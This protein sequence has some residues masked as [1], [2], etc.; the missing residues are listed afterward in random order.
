MTDPRGFLTIERR[1][2][3]YRPVEARRRDWDDVNAAAADDLVREQARRCMD[4]G[5]PFCHAGCPLGNLI[6]DW[7]DLV[8]RGR[9]RDALDRLHATNNFPEFTGKLCP[10]P[11]EE[12]CV[13]QINDDAVTIKQVE[14][15][16]VDRGFARGWIRPRPPE[17]TTSH[18]VAVIGSGP[19]GLAAAQQLRRRGHAVVVYERDDRIGGL[20]RYG[21]PDFKL[22]KRDID[23]RL[24]QL[25]AEGVAFE[26]GVTVDDL[27][28]LE[29]DAVVLATGAQ[30]HRDLD[31]PGRDLAGIGLA[32]PYLTA[33]NRRVAGLPAESVTA[34][35][36]RVVILGGGDTGADCLGAAIREGA[37]SVALVGHGVQPPEHREPHRTWPDWPKLLR[38]YA[39]HLEGGDRLFE[40]ETTG[41]AGE[42]AVARLE[43]R[44]RDGSPAA[45]DVD[46][47]LVAVGFTGI[48]RNDRVY[49]NV[50][51]GPRDTVVVDAG[52]ATSRPGVFAAGDCVRGADL[53][54]TA[55]A[56]G[57]RCAVAVDAYLSRQ[58]VA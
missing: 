42:A 34:S 40:L 49:A 17:R 31:L 4:C 21:I 23:R 30:R 12:A 48:E 39:A 18:R 41:F 6:P 8:E 58:P 32:M 25:V 36:R 51:V 13:L 1:V 38:T 10:A 35:G 45:L 29:A 54:V 2:A 46:M 55:I 33:C 19:A 16:I 26:T 52:F 3:G 53:I 20:L 57:R 22:A 15:A 44:Y 14:Q 27:D 47:V 24:E 7:N 9:W 28:A 37:T 50:A 43:G 5:V 11:C 56:D